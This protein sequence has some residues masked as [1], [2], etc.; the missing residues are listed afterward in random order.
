VLSELCVPTEPVDCCDPNDKA[1][2][3]NLPVALAQIYFMSLG[4]FSA[5][6]S[7]SE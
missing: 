3:I 4:T 5:E 6:D 2:T 1:E 7:L